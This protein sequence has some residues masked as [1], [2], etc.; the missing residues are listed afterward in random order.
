MSLPP[1][2]TGLAT[3]RAGARRYGFPRTDV[4]RYA[5]HFGLGNGDTAVWVAA[6]GALVGALI[7][8]ASIWSK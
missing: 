5:R 4:E 2:G 1:R 7:I 6:G 3:G 8:L